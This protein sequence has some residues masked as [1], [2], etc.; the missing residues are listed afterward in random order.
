MVVHINVLAR[1]IKLQDVSLVEYGLIDDQHLSQTIKKAIAD[2][3]GKRLILPDTPLCLEDLL[4]KEK[5]N[6]AIV[7]N[8]LFPITCKD[9][10]IA[11]CYDFDLS[12]L[13]IKGTKE[14]FA[15]FYIVGDCQNFKI[16]DCL[17]DSE[18]GN[19]GHYTFYGIH[20]FV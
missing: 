3:D 10:R 16:H 8:I 1:E 18:I 13:Y 19:D 6:F 7:S 15:S 2:I 20:I 14:R 9:F 11:D 12:N 5:H 4:I 17:F